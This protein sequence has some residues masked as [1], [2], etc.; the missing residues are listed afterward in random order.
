MRCVTLH[1]PSEIFSPNVRLTVAVPSRNWNLFSLMYCLILY[2]SPVGGHQSNLV[3]CLHLDKSIWAPSFNFIQYVFAIQSCHFHVGKQGKMDKNYI[4]FLNGV[5]D[6]VGAYIKLLKFRV[7]T[8]HSCHK[9]N[10]VLGGEEGE[11]PR[12]SIEEWSDFM[13]LEVL[14]ESGCKVVQQ[15]RELVEAGAS[16][17]L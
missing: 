12:R 15:P 14:V 2:C 10:R 7:R 8:Q 6:S 4:W 5:V 13:L 9:G 11:E 1:I 3:S 17:K 16:A